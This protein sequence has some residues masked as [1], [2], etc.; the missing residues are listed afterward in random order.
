[1]SF[2][3]SLSG[4]WILTIAGLVGIPSLAYA[5]GVAARPMLAPG[6]ILAQSGGAEWGIFEKLLQPG[7]LAA[8]TLLLFNVIGFMKGWIVP[9]YVYDAEKDRADRMEA[10]AITATEALKSAVGA[11]E[12]TARAILGNNKP[13]PGSPP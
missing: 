8:S 4:R 11:V 13:P 1:M 6:G 5:A 9:K 12:N 10:R 2:P 3:R 7:N